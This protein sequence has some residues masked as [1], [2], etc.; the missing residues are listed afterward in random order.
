MHPQWLFYNISQVYVDR[1][2]LKNFQ[3]K[4]FKEVPAYANPRSEHYAPELA[5]AIKIHKAVE[6]H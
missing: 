1:A 4:D 6:L 2:D 3:N 5:L